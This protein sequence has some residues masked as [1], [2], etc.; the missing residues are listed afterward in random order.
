MLEVRTKAIMKAAAEKL[1]SGVSARKIDTGA[2]RDTSPFL[3]FEVEECR[4]GQPGAEKEF[5]SIHVLPTFL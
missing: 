3:Q 5:L 4:E 2:R 1:K